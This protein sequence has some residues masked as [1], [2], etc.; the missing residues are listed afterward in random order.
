MKVTWKDLSFLPSEEAM[1]ELCSAWSWLLPQP[2]QPVMVSTFGDVFFQQGTQAV[3]WLNTGTAEITQVAES[4]AEFTELLKGDAYVEW[5]LPNLV[6][7]LKEAGKILEPDHCYTYVTLPTFK[8]GK[9]EVANLNPVPA[10]DHF[11]V[12]GSMHRQ[13]RGLPDGAR[14]KISV[15]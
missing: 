4:R 1:A 14:V 13:L 12:T 7:Q 10:K 15:V 3:Y 8:E 5:F 9:Y 11:A 2:F 6:Q